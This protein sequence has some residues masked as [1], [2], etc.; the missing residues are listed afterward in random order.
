[1]RL[2]VVLSIH[3]R[4][5]LFRHG[6]FSFT[7]QTL[8]TK[9]FELIVIDDMSTE[10]IR[11]YLNEWRKKL[12]IRYVRIDHTKHWL[13][14]EL[15]PNPSDNTFANWYHTP[16]LSNNIGFKLARGEV[17][18][19]TQPEIIQAPNN[20]MIGYADALTNHFIFGKT[21]LTDQRFTEW[22]NAA[23]WKDLYYKELLRV[24]GA[25]H[26]HFPRGVFYWYVA[27]LRTEHALK[28]NGV[29]EEYL[30]GVY[31]EDDNFRIRVQL[32]GIWPKDNW[33]IEGIHV[34]HSHESEKHRRRNEAHWENGARTN[35]ARFQQFLTDIRNHEYVKKNIVV[36]QEKDWGSMDC[37]I[38]DELLY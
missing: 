28:L 12:N 26:Y 27:F 24:P 9:D 10:N 37:V 18:M 21:Y 33:D 15:N 35:R 3:N 14:H 25:S 38:K 8:P 20:L 22:V 17:L 30:R 19:I 4:L 5:Q 36:N 6:L 23:E 11:E 32:S 7:Q 16:A 13:F 2:S 34:D 31:A 29:D 1:M